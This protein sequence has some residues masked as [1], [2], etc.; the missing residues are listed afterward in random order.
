[1]NN[2]EQTRFNPEGKKEKENGK[3]I[4]E[5]SNSDGGVTDEKTFDNKTQAANYLYNFASHQSP[6]QEW[7]TLKEGEKVIGQASNGFGAEVWVEGYDKAI[8][9]N[10]S[11]LLKNKG[12]NY[13][14]DIKEQ[15]EKSTKTIEYI[16]PNNNTNS[17]GEK[18]FRLEEGH[19]FIVS[20]QGDSKR[21]RP[22]REFIEKLS[23]IAPFMD[24]DYISKLKD[25]LPWLEIDEKTGDI[26]E[27]NNGYTVYHVEDRLNLPRG[28]V[29]IYNV[30]DGDNH[31]EMARNKNTGETYELDPGDYQAY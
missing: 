25:N 21:I 10:N 28:S 16:F 2:P 5:I 7:A 26:I 4:I 6:E 22:T 12:G 15:V 1:M 30:G 19:D 17:K 11:N 31:K 23:E 24:N 20:G 27:L 8:V 18:S 29:E 9:S 13:P 3:I 14:E